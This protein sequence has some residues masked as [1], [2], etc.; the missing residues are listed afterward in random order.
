MTRFILTVALT[1]LISTATLAAPNACCATCPGGDCRCSA[2]GHSVYDFTR[3]PQLGWID[4]R[5]ERFPAF[6]QWVT[7]DNGITNFIPADAE[8]KDVV[9]MKDGL[10]MAS[11]V[12]EGLQARDL[13]VIAY[14]AFERKG[15]PSILLRAQTREEIVRGRRSVVTGKTLS[16]VLYEKGINLWYFNGEKWSKAG[17]AT[18]EV[19]PGVMHRVK[20]TLTGSCA[21]V[22]LDGKRVVDV[23]DLELTDCGAVGIWAGEGPCTFK[24]LLV[25]TCGPR[26]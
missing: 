15:A 16:L 21:R 9:A 7:S 12:I 24:S 23:T 10:G 3:W 1:A 17:A 5:E 20:A 8:E 13:T 4:A 26:G 18:L 22:W 6:G 14:M 19:E 25:R 2:V 11:S